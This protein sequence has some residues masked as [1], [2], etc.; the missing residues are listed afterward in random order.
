MESF[1]KNWLKKNSQENQRARDRI[2]AQNQVQVSI[3]SLPSTSN[4]QLPITASTQSSETEPV[5]STS[6]AVI[7]INSTSD[8]VYQKDGLQLLV[9]KG[10]FQRQKKISLQAY[11]LL[12]EKTYYLIIKYMTNLR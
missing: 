3:D 11:I 8:I 1:Y 2:A 9:E 6:K 7:K 5:A 12:F 4:A 10:V